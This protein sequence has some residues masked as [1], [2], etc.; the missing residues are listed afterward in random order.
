[1]S[2][3]LRG[4]VKEKKIGIQIFMGSKGSKTSKKGEFE[5]PEQSKARSDVV[6]PVMAAMSSQAVRLI[7]R[8]RTR[9]RISFKLK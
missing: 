8:E 6:P 5:G 9:E 1:M 3:D 7:T 2:K 4:F